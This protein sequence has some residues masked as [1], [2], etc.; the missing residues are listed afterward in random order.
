MSDVTE[1]LGDEG[2]ETLASRVYDRLLQDIVALAIEPGEKLHIR[3]ATLRCRTEPDPRGAEP[4][5]GRRTGRPERSSWLCRQAV[6][7]GRSC[8]FDARA[9]SAESAA[10]E[11][12]VVL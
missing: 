2:K 4:F 6:E 3:C 5:V 8:R 10:W 12:S 1:D 7:R 9:M 11:E